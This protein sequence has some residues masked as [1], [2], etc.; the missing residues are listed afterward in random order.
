MREQIEALEDHANLPTL[1]GNI[2]LAILN[3]PASGLAIADEVAIDQDSARLH[4][5]QMIEAADKVRLS[6][7]RSA[8]DDDHLP[9]PDRQRNSFQD[10]DL[11]EG[12]ANVGRL[13]HGFRRVGRQAAD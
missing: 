10:F 12:L 2:T 6:G 1:V 13:D 3:H 8:D 9:A 7:A 4:P 5:F 11:S